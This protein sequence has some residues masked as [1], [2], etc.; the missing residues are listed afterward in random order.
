[1]HNK[2]QKISIAYRQWEKRD[3]ELCCFSSARYSG[4]AWG[5]VFPVHVIQV[6]HE[7]LI[8]QCTF[9]RYG[10]RICFSSARYSGVGCGFF[11]QCTL[12]RSGMRICF[13]SPR[14]LGVA[15]VFFWRNSVCV[16]GR[17]QSEE[18]E[19]R[20]ADRKEHPINI[21]I[22]WNILELWIYTLYYISDLIVLIF[23]N[24]F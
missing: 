3:C 20:Q 21:N 17:L 9:F 4:V 13:S 2:C 10:M 24:Q 23:I 16:Y 8:F 7:D 5:F 6:W 12:F 1:M 14:Y 22:T 11:F 15:W 18:G 19:G